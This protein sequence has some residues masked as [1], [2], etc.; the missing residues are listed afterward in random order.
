[1]RYTNWRLLYFTRPLRGLS[2]EFQSRLDLCPQWRT[3]SD[4]ILYSRLGDRSDLARKK[5]TPL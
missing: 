4:S 2:T 1:M 5:T 3:F